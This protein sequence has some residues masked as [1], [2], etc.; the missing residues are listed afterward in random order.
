M[1][2]KLQSSSQNISRTYKEIL[3]KGK[4]SLFHSF[5]LYV[6]FL[7]TLVFDELNIF[8]FFHPKV[9]MAVLALMVSYKREYLS[10]TALMFITILIDSVY[11]LTAGLTCCTYMMFLFLVYKSLNYQLKPLLNVLAISLYIAIALLFQWILGIIIGNK[12]QI[13]SLF[14][15]CI[16][17]SIIYLFLHF[18]IYKQN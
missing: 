17:T 15:T 16:S 9:E 13:S 7:I 2:V 6:S 10:F 11:N 12:I 14:E 5:A 1:D 3:K 4:K 18:K 8:D